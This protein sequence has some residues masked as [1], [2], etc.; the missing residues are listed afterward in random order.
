MAQM[1]YT[2]IWPDYQTKQKGPEYAGIIIS[3]FQDALTRLEGADGSGYIAPSKNSSG[4]VLYTIVGH[5]AGG[6]LAYGLATLLPENGLADPAAV[7]TVEPA[8]KDNILTQNLPTYSAA[9][10]SPNTLVITVVGDQE[11]STEICTAV[12][13][14][15]QMSSISAIYKPFLLDRS[16]STGNPAQ[17]G[18]IYFPLTNSTK[19]TDPPPTSVDDRDYNITYKLSVAAAA[20]TIGSAN[21]ASGSYCDYALGNGPPNDYGATTQTNM[22]L[23]SSG[24]P[25][26]PMVLLVDPVTYF[27]SECK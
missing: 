12:T 3:D 9:G 24:S 19:D 25:V 16:D 17:L 7:F 4:G 20:C 15:T 14:W 21:L 18:N 6:Y 5:Q 11:D 1:G 13:A 8:Q 2:V 27:Q 10:I 22:G 26:L 23:W